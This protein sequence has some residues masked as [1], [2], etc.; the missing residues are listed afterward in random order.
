MVTNLFGLSV[1]N[2]S[3]N[4]LFCKPVLKHLVLMVIDHRGA[5]EVFKVF[6]SFFFN[7]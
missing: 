6:A 7:L 3:V 2:I 5:M 1:N 4:G